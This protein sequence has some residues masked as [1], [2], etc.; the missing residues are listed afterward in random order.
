MPRIFISYRRDDSAGHTGRIYDRLIDRFGR[1]QVFMDVD[2]V[3]P[4]LDYIQVVHEA[5]GTCDGLIAVIGREW[6]QA[7][8]ATGVRRLENPADL[9]RL[10][11]ATALERDIRVIPVLVQGVQMPLEIELPEGLKGLASRNALEVSDTRFR[12]DVDRLIEALEVPTPEQLADSVFVESPQ[13]VGSVFV[14]RGR[15]LG[16]LNTALEQTLDGHGRLVMLA[17]EPGIGKTRTA[18]ELAS[19]AELNGA[20]VLWGRCVDEEGAPPYWPWLQVLRDYVQGAE[21]ERLYSEMASGAAAIGEMVSEVRAKLPDLEPLSALEPQQARFRLFDSITK[22]FKSITQTQPLMLILDDLHWADRASL[23]F[24]QFLTRE[25]GESR[26]LIVGTYRHMELSRQHP[27]SE[28]LAQLTR[29]PVFRRELL[30]GLSQEDTGQFIEAT[31][32]VRPPQELVETIYSHT[33]GNPFFMTEVVRLLS[34]E[35]RLTPEGAQE[36]SSISIPEGVRE[37]IGQ[38]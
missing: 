12:Y 11:I 36:F 34:E 38:R 30:S 31:A 9:V 6:L 25:I 28:T 7:S 22:F 15:E 14:G 16:V 5:I 32:G 1:G 35:N 2:T 23:R 26:L 20:L 24:L 33:E 37:V 17:G 29:E 21:P 10:E 27:L 19:R 3:Q 18:Q 4:G 13:P 8:D